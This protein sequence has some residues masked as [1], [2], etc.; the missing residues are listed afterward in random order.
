MGIWNGIEII[1]HDSERHFVRQVQSCPIIHISEDRSFS[2]LYKDYTDYNYNYGRS[3]DV[4]YDLTTD[5]ARTYDPSTYTRNTDP[6]NRDPYN[7]DKDQYHRTPQYRDPIN[8]DP[9]NRNSYPT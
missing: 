2:S 7:R 6:Y 9:Y 4:G 5:R 3:S 8:R 1:D